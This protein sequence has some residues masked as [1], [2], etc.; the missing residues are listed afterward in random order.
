MPVKDTKANIPLGAYITLITAFSSIMSLV[1]FSQE[2]NRH[3]TLDEVV[4]ILSLE[5]TSAKIERLNFHNERLSFENYRK[6]LLPSLSF[7]MNPINFNRSL[8]TL[9]QPTDGS[10]SYVEDY[11]NS[12]SWGLTV[13]QRVDFTGGELSIGTRLNYLNEFSQKRNSFSTTPFIIGYSQQLWGGR[14]THRLEKNIEYAKNEAAMKNYCS[15]LSEVQQ[16]A[17]DLFMTALLGKLEYELEFRNK[18]INDTLLY[19]ARTKLKNGNIT[20]FDFKQIE[21]QSLNTRYSY[22][23]AMRSYEE[24]LQELKTYLALSEELLI[25]TPEFN[26]PLAIDFHKVSLLVKKNN[27]FSIQQLITKLQAEQAL[28]ST[29]LTNRFNGNLS[30]SYGMNQHADNLVEAYHRGNSQQSFILGFQIPVFQWRISRNKIRMAQNTHQASLLSQYKGQQ[31][32]DDRIREKVNNYNHSV[33]LWLVAE[34][35]YTISREQYQMSAR[36]FTLGKVSVYELTSAQRDQNR[37]MKQ[38]YTAIRDA[39]R[40]YYHLR[41]MA[42]YDWKSEKELEDIFLKE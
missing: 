31:E 33:R 41:H 36:E 34:K 32:F 28:Y 12:S 2:N 39:Y 20:E 16:E 19:I 24:S 13:R 25:A 8:K 26:L 35:A 6:G 14:K 38:Y 42:L 5:S 4:N 29:K 21:L 10:Y 15:R 22:E 18:E 11:S 9:Q 27:P 7:S 37:G 1:A 30:L 23:N 40:E 17:L 3:I